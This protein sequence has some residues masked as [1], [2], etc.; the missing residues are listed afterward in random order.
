MATDMLGSSR[1]STGTTNFLISVTKVS[2]ENRS[3]EISPERD[4]KMGGIIILLIKNQWDNFP[5][6]TKLI[7]LFKASNGKN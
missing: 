2:F 5:S 3:I 4:F 7:I 6:R 1:F